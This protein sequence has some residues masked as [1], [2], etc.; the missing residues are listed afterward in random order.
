MKLMYSF[1]ISYYS[2]D[3]GN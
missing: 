2:T 1:R 3:R